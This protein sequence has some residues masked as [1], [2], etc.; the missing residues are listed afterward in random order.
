MKT[1]LERECPQIKTTKVVV[2][3]LASLIGA[4]LIYIVSLVIT[5]NL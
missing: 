3:T 5:G 4:S 2:I 1:Q